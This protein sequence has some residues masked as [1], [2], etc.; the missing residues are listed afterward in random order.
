MCLNLAKITYLILFI[1][2]NFFLMQKCE[3]ESREVVSYQHFS[4]D[5]SP[6]STNNYSTPLKNSGNNHAIAVAAATV[7]ATEAAV[8]AAQAAAKV[9]RLAG[10][11]HK[12]Y[13]KEE[14]AATVI[15][16]YYRGHL[17]INYLLLFCFFYSKKSLN[18]CN[19]NILPTNY[20]ILTTTFELH[21]SLRKLLLR[22]FVSFIECD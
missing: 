4:I 5:S 14:R 9:V 6:E 3:E 17:V 8:A 7:A 16:T 13:S 11:G 1:L 18:T 22:S 21:A 20:F 15:Q 19:C 12:Y 10:Y 2:N